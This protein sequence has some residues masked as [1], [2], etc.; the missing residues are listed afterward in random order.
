MVLP[1]REKRKRGKY[2]CKKEDNC[3]YY[4]PKHCPSS[5]SEKKCFSEECTLVH[6]VGSKRQ[7]C[8]KEQSYR[9]SHQQLSRS[10]DSSRNSN[11]PLIFAPS[12]L[13]IRRSLWNLPSEVWT[14]SKQTIPQS[15]A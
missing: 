10:G 11:G 14:F 4:H 7:R 15:V 13:Q 2:G 9:R 5:V 12:H 3:I 8:P 6:L 1:F